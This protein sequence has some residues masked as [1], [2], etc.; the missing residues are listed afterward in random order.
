[1]QNGKD[2]MPKPAMRSRMVA[3]NRAPV[4]MPTM[5]ALAKQRRANKTLTYEEKARARDAAKN[6]LPIRFQQPSSHDVISA[7]ERLN[8]LESVI[9]EKMGIS[10]GEAEQI[11]AK[12]AKAAFD[13]LFAQEERRI[14]E[15]KELYAEFYKA[16]FAIFHDA[17]IPF[18]ND[19]R[20][21]WDSQITDDLS[22]A[23]SPPIS[24]I[25]E[26]TAPA[27]ADALALNDAEAFRA[28]IMKKYEGFKIVWEHDRWATRRGREKFP[29][30]RYFKVTVI[31]KVA[32]R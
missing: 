2:K 16:S 5:R 19:E 6:A 4:K 8:M 10:L 17:F 15:Q 14:L 20:V 23:K 21:N 27:I 25:L 7:I 13:E 18:I 3:A 11:H 26:T 32:R 12:Q 29:F 24:A 28:E 31:F 22:R 9:Y 1:M 30:E